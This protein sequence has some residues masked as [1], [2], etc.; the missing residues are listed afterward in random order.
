MTGNRILPAIRAR[1]GVTFMPTI[2][3][4]STLASSTGA[5][6]TNSIRSAPVTNAAN[7]RT[8]TAVHNEM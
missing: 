5:D 1:P 3:T 6:V 2:A 8:I 7:P 4:R